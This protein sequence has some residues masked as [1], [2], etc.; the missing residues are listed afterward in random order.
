[1]VRV[2]EPKESEWKR[3][4][5]M[6]VIEGKESYSALR[7]NTGCFYTACRDRLLACA[8]LERSPYL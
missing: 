2:K 7:D 3:W 1:M 4:V 6:L 5:R 8:T